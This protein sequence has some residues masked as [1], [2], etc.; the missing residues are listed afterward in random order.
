MFSVSTVDTL[1]IA[2]ITAIHLAGRMPLTSQ[3]RPVFPRSH[4]IQ[5]SFL[6]LIQLEHV[7]CKMYKPNGLLL[8]CLFIYLCITMMASEKNHLVRSHRRVGCQV[9]LYSLYDKRARVRWLPM[10]IKSLIYYSPSEQVRLAVLSMGVNNLKRSIYPH[11]LPRA[12]TAWVCPQ[13]YQPSDDE[14]TNATY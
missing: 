14:L 4:S 8:I 7:F 9:Y 2:M 3:C 11:A 10:L 6:G 1:R 12:S 5:L 13:I